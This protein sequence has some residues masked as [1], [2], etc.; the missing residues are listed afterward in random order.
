MEEKS[1]YQLLCSPDFLYYSWL[2][3][4]SKKGASGVDGQEIWQFKQNLEKNLLRISRE[5]QEE[6]YEP[7]PLRGVR[8]PKDKPGDF[9][10]IGV[11]TVRD[12]VVFRGVNSL[13]QEIWDHQFS[14]L[15]FGYRRGRG[16]RQAIKAVTRQT[17][18][19]KTWFVRG[20]IRGCFDSFDW[21]LLSTIVRH[22]MP[23][24]QLLKLL[25]KAVRVPVVERGRIMPRRRGV[26]QG[27]PV[28]PILANLYLHIF[29]SGMNRSGYNIIRYGDDWIALVDS[30]ENALAC[31]YR[32]VDCLED[33]RISISP[34]KSGIGDL[35]Q[36]P[37]DF[38]GFRIDAWKAEAGPKAWRWLSKAVEEYTTSENPVKRQRALGELMNICR[39]YRRSSDIGSIADKVVRSAW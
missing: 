10:N 31:F 4:Q 15:S 30:G 13:L 32:A 3:V 9:R 21:N 24:P 17:K 33:L 8:I 28:S 29:D 35:R 23:D 27:S 11:P 1:L 5:L 6:R 16:V 25:N 37:I 38:L 39:V 14:S 2:G 18:K 36:V 22:A 19:G 26:P 12:R 7:S 20:D 34:E